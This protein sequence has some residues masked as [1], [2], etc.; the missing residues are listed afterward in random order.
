MGLWI[1]ILFVVLVV[2][3]YRYDRKIESFDYYGR[4]K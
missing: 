1:I 4:D 3:A 2:R